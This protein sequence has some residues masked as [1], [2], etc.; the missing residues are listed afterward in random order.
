VAGPWAAYALVTDISIL[1]GVDREEFLSAKGY[2]RLHTRAIQGSVS[3]V[4]SRRRRSPGLQHDSYR[5]E[6]L[7]RG[8]PSRD[9]APHS[10][11]RAH[12]WRRYG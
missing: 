7:R 11:R 4:K 1:A 6:H 12:S 2:A 10:R 8:G 3:E 9:V 5:C